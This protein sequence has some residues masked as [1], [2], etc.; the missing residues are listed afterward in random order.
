VVHKLGTTGTAS[1]AEIKGLMAEKKS[2]NKV[3]LQRPGIDPESRTD[4][5]ADQL[6]E[7]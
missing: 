4:L 5:V 1:V 6:F 7:I 3:S 2:V